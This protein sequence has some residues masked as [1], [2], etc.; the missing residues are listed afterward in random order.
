M[1][2]D[3]L[4][5]CSITSFILAILSLIIV[6][7][8]FNGYGLLFMFIFICIGLVFDQ[9]SKIY[10]SHSEVNI[11][12]V[13]KKNRF[14]RLF[15]LIFFSTSPIPLIYGNKFPLNWNIILFICFIVVGI[16]LDQVG[17]ICY[18]YNK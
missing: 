4:R 2:R 14:F 17:R 1:K 13:Y 8:Y 15:S 7:W 11:E 5:H 10:F 16:I 6:D 18:P 3:T 9:L 12:S